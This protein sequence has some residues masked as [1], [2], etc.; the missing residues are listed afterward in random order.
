MDGHVLV[1]GGAGYVGSHVVRRLHEQRRPVVA[2]DTLENGARDALPEGVLVAGDAGDRVLVRE[3]LR[4]FAVR[5]VVHL[6]AYTRVAESVGDPGRYYR[7]NAGASRALIECCGAA[8]VEHF[9]FASSAA[10]Y[11]TPEAPCVDEDAPARPIN[12]YGGSKL[13]TE[14]M[15]R[16]VAATTPMRCTALRC[17]NVAGADPRGR[18]GPSRH[19][20]AA[21]VKAACEAALGKRDHVPVHGTDFP[22]ADGTCVRDY[23]HVEDVAQA[24]LDALGALEAG[25]GSQV[26][27]CG[28]GHGASVLEV[29]AAVER[30]AGVTI[31]AR[32][33]PRRA[34]DPPC[35]VADVRRIRGRLG[36]APRH[37]GLAP[38]VETALEWERRQSERPRRRAS[39]IG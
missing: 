38:I 4:R 33:A 20:A 30:A 24:H 1:T 37:R 17:F 11:G 27:N 10:V 2:L 34:G 35:L 26:L 15:L 21:L 9:V 29:V 18:T 22:T 8:G 3:V 7:N 13:M 5:S 16:A 23:V 14:R 36:W 6:A 39:M 28:G 31:D 25:G 12:P 19:H 32:E